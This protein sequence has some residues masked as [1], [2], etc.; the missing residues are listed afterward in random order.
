MKNEIDAR[1]NSPLTTHD[2][3][4]GAQGQARQAGSRA[5]GHVRPP[6]SLL[7]THYS[8]ESVRERSSPWRLLVALMFLLTSPALAQQRP[9]QSLY[10]FDPL[11]VNPAYA[12]TH[13]QLSGTAIYRN[14]W[15][16]FDGAPK[17]FTGTIHSGF[18]KA[19]VGL[20]L[21]FT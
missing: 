17:T 16:N 13:V 9:I 3:P 14:Q 5:G 4:A 10:M 21:I 6:H 1:T 19:R 7:T 18:R 15:V 2:L 12:G 11:L 20:G 8:P